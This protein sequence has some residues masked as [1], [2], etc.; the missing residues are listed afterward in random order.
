MKLLL[1]SLL[2]VNPSFAGSTI[3]MYY[4]HDEPLTSYSF[5]S[6][7]RKCYYGDSMFGQSKYNIA[8][9]VEGFCPRTIYVDPVA[10]TWSEY[11]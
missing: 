6:S 5:S 3:T 2:F 9:I 11:P 7:F 1:M 8:V 4:D 10:G